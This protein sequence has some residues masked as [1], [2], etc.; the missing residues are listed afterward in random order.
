[1]E[2]VLH[3]DHCGYSLWKC[4]QK[5]LENLEFESLDINLYQ[6]VSPMLV[7][8]KQIRQQCFGIDKLDVLDDVIVI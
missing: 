6:A 4:F 5:R 3:D 2:K 8:R 1:M 7:G